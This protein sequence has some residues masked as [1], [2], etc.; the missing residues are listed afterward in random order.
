[1]IKHFG[2]Y[3]GYYLW[4]LPGRHGN[5]YKLRG[6]IEIDLFGKSDGKG[7]INL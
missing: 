3:S 1:L 6:K 2:C 5:S 4:I 7:I